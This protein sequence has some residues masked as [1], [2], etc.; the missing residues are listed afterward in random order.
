MG[1][2]LWRRGEARF[3]PRYSGRKKEEKEREEEEPLVGLSQKIRY[4]VSDPNLDA[5][6]L[7]LGP[8]PNYRT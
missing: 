4:P 8:I 6:E 2:W 5:V 3:G 7:H 1:Y